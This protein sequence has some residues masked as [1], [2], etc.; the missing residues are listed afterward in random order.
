MIIYNLFPLLAGNF[1]NWQS[2]IDR[3]ADIG[4]DWIFVNPVQ[5]PGQSGSLYSIADYFQ[6]NPRLVD[7]SSSLSPEDQLKSAVHAAESRGVHMMVDLVINHCASD[8]KLAQEHPEW[9]VREAD[10]RIAHPY[11]LPAPT[12]VDAR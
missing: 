7:P 4:F 11:C 3:A 5:K 9:F 10:G 2:H 8:S 1:G 12:P 6:L